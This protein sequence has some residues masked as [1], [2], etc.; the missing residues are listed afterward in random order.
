MMLTIFASSSGG[1]WSG[2]SWGGDALFL[3]IL[4]AL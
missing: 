2:S 1:L 4:N 3:Y